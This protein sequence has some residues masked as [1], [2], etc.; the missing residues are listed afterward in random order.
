MNTPNNKRRRDSRDRLETAFVRLLQERELHQVTVTALCEEARVNRTTF[1]ANYLDLYDLADAVQKRLEGE[2]FALY[3]EEREGKKNTNDFLK[4]FR[5]IYENQLFYRTYF[6]LGLDGRF[7]VTE[8]DVRQ[9]AEY[10]PEEDIDYHIEFFR[11]GLNAVIK[12]WLRE[13]CR[14]TP[15]EICAVIE[16][17]YRGKTGVGVPSSTKKREKVRTDY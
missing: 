12:K 10:Y 8:Y 14:E 4:L 1:Y 16:A 3:R 2:V 9:A 11:A 13:G 15:E 5:H 6:K 17:E 7:Q